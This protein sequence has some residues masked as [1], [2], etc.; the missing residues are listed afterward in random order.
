MAINQSFSLGRLS[1]FTTHYTHLSHQVKEFPVNYVG[2]LDV[3]R[4]RLGVIAGGRT[5]TVTAGAGGSKHYIDD[6]G[7]E[8][9]DANQFNVSLLSFS[10]NESST[11]ETQ[12][13]RRRRR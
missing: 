13:N 2:H 12:S 11:T 4:Q 7:L 10:V 6:D 8:M 5:A 3:T 1:N 9:V